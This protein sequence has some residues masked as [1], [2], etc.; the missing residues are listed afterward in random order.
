MYAN[1]GLL[2][3]EWGV[4]EVGALLTFDVMI[5]QYGLGMGRVAAAWLIINRLMLTKSTILKDCE[6]PSRKVV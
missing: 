2:W 5:N 4:S 1:N 3:G 6:N